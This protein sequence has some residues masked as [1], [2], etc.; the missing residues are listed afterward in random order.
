VTAIEGRPSKHIRAHLQRRYDPKNQLGVWTLSEDKA[1]IQSVFHRLTARLLLNSHRRAVANLGS[2]WV[3]ISQLVGRTSS[4][5]RDRYRNHLA[6]RDVRK[7][8]EHLCRN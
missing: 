8:G 3:D 2:K 7:T 5:C 6:H 4:D 1:L